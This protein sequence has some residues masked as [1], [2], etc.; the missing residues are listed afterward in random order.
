MITTNQ[1][2]WIAGLLEGEGS[3]G[4][5][6][7]PT[8]QLN[9]IDL[10]VIEKVR[11][12]IKPDANIGLIQRPSNQ[13]QYKINISS[14]KAIEWMM[15][16]YPL[17]SLRRKQQIQFVLDQWRQMKRFLPS[18]EEQAIKAIAYQRNIP[19]EEA[20]RL[21]EAVKGVQ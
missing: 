18:K 15:T 1:I 10:D 20:K 14:I 8:I 13:T 5:H 6:K 21:F 3:F 11:Y 17:M 2:H 4:F 7:T 12:I 19:Y 9:M 16:I